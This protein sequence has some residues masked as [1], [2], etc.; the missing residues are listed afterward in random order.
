VKAVIQANR[1]DFFYALDRTTGKVLLSKAYTRITWADGIDS[2]GRPV[3]IAGQEPTEEGNRTCPGMG[4]GHNWQATAYSPLTGLYY[5]TST[6]RCMLFYKTKQSS[7]KA[8]GIRAAPLVAMSLETGASTPSIRRPA[9][10][11]G[12][13]KR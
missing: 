13:S 7:K 9:N 4:G 8:S 11:R 3:P 6:E 5:F 12:T 2:D 1:N 10:S